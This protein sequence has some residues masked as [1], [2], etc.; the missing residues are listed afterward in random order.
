MKGARS[1]CTVASEYAL[2]YKPHLQSCLLASTITSPGAATPTKHRSTRLCPVI[3]LA[4]LGVFLAGTIAAA[5][6]AGTYCSG[7]D[8]DT[9]TVVMAWNQTVS[10]FQQRESGEPYSGVDVMEI[11]DGQLVQKI[12]LYVASNFSKYIVSRSVPQQLTLYPQWYDIFYAQYILRGSSLSYSFSLLENISLP[13]YVLSS[14]HDYNQLKGRGHP[15]LL[16]H[17]DIT[18]DRNSVTFKVEKDSYIFVVVN[19]TS[20]VELNVTA[21]ESLRLYTPP[22]SY[23]SPVCTLI[24]FD[25]CHI[26]LSTHSAVIGVTVPDPVGL[27]YPSVHTSSTMKK[28]S[29]ACVTSLVLLC[30]GLLAFST[31]AATLCIV[32]VYCCK[33]NGSLFQHR[34]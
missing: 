29:V 2:V 33:R 19:I 24:T 17:W 12:E 21:H 10:V 22:A 9:G 13:L 32:L 26:K 5:S 15:T 34:V 18:H 6:L 14:F 3:V 25:P 30:L 27:H 1:T 8:R 16:H 7:D 23:M 20:Y 28:M 31:L 4:L 11:N